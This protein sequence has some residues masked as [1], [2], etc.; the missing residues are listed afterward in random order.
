MNET[1]SGWPNWETWNVNLWLNN[2]EVMYKHYQ[3]LDSAKELETYVRSKFASEGKLGDLDQASE[4][5]KVDFKE[6]VRVKQL[7]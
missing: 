5:D 2:D 7:D 3:V 1:Y 4:L 6:I